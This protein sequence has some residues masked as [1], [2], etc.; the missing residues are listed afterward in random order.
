[1]F[2][3]EKTRVYRHQVDA[4]DEEQIKKLAELLGHTGS[5]FNK[6]SV[7]PVCG[8]LQWLQGSN[9]QFGENPC[10]AHFIFAS[11]SDYECEECVAVFRRAPEVVKWVVNVISFAIHEATL[12]HTR[13]CHKESGN[14][15]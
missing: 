15:R 1:M 6:Y 10:R 12:D 5:R 13:R 14:G 4:G 2:T 8:H 9:E 11:D 7:C 3:Y